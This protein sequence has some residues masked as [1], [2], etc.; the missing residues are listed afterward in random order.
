MK[1]PEKNHDWSKA[2]QGGID[3]KGKPSYRSEP[4]LFWGL[5]NFLALT[6]GAY[7]GSLMAGEFP[8]LLGPALYFIVGIVMIPL[9]SMVQVSQYG[10][11]F[12]S[13]L[14]GVNNYILGTYIVGALLYGLT[15][16]LK[17]NSGFFILVVVA[18]GLG[19]FIAITTSATL[20]NERDR[21]QVTTS[22]D[23]E[24]ENLGESVPSDDQ[25]V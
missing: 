25:R 4:K 23:P 13:I 3:S 15:L 18:F 21:S 6:V 22:I 14:R 20:A 19:Y 5:T 11:M 2:P 24:L 8:L 9:V 12:A 16:Y 10:K 7:L 1:P 17:S